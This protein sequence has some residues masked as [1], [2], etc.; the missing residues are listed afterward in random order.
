MRKN[1]CD[2]FNAENDTLF[3]I[4]NRE[5]VTIVPEWHRYDFSMIRVLQLSHSDTVTI[6]LQ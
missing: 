3:A 5:T 6:V 4:S 1:V 2:L